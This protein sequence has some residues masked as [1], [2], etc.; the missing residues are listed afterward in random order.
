[1]GVMALHPAL[2]ELF[3]NGNAALQMQGWM[4]AGAMVAGLAWAVGP[5]LAR[6]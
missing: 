3:G 5:G 2:A 6:R 1:L 4:V